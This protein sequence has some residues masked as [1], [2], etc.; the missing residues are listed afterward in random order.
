MFNYAKMDR[1][2]TNGKL[3]IEVFQAVKT[4]FLAE[5]YFALISPISDKVYKEAF[6]LYM[7]TIADNDLNRKCETNIGERLTD[8]N[9]L[10]MADDEVCCKI[11]DFHSLGMAQEGFTAEAPF[12]PVKIAEHNIIKAKHALIEVMEQFT[13]LSSDDLLLI[14]YRERYIKLVTGLVV[15]LADEQK[16]SFK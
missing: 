9:K 5:A 16:L 8:P 13:G 15:Q 10:Y 7:P 4:L 12:C 14:H 1:I 2:N 11:Y 6:D 3:D